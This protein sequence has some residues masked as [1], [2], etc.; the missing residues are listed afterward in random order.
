MSEQPANEA[1]QEI[2]LLENML[3]MAGIPH[4]MERAL[5]GWHVI[6]PEA[7]KRMVCSIAEFRGTY[8]AARDQLE[9]Q[10]LLNK[11]E[12]KYDSVVGF[13]S[14]EKVFARIQAD[15]ERRKKR[16]RK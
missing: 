15:W 12:R 5:D 8:G 3:T 16:N 1:Y 6:Y 10:G 9:I 7:G 13:L 4:V 2:L 14:A 11:A